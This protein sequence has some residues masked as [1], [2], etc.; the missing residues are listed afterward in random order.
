MFHVER[1]KT[2]IIYLFYVIIKPTVFI[3]VIINVIFSK[4]VNI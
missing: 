2:Y 3:N 4:K 1:K